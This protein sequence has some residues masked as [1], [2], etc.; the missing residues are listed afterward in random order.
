MESF[1][2]KLRDE[3][4]DREVFASVQEARVQL[5]TY[6]HWYNKERPHSILKYLPPATFRQQWQIR[7]MDGLTKRPPARP[8]H[9]LC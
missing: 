9:S 6:R 8:K 5:E 7:K 3:L 2:G 1:H 4:L